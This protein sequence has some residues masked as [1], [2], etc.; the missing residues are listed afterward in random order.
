MRAGETQSYI[1]RYI[2]T[3]VSS[4][5]KRVKEKNESLF[6]KKD[7]NNLRKVDKKESN[8]KVCKCGNKYIPT[9]KSPYKCLLCHYGKTI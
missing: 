6:S 9:P 1:K 2:P 5:L 7:W 3:L 4:R 8:V